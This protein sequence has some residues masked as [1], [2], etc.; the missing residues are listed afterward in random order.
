MAE[1][2]FKGFNDATETAGEYNQFSFIVERMLN[3]LHTAT[4]VQIESCTN[5]GGVTPVGFVDVHPLVNQISGDGT[6][7]KH[8]IIHHI[9]YLRIQGGQNA[10]IL[11]PQRG[12]I[13]ICLFAERD[14]SSVKTNKTESNPGSYR[15]YN[16]SDGLYIGGVLNGSPNQ[17][18][19][20]SSTGIDITS[21]YKIRL[22]GD[23]DSTGTFTNNGKNIGSTHVHPDPQGG[24]TGTPQ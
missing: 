8:G 23:V 2:T 11:D 24:T 10:I 1:N 6:P 14:I 3:D 16:W 4:L 7:V 15:K 20:F 18:I 21:P 19:E 17:Y 13:G 9:P 12:D 5:S 22:N